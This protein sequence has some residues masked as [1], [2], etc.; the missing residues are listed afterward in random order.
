[1]AAEHE[2]WIA[3]LFSDLTIKD[4]KELMRLLAKTKLSAHNAITKGD[5]S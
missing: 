2:G 3:G 1:M 5:R 4:Q